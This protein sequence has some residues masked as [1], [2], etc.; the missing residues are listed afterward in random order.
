[1]QHK[2]KVRNSSVAHSKS[3]EPIGRQEKARPHLEQRPIIICVNV[4][5][6]ITCLVSRINLFRSVDQG[7]KI[8][9]TVQ[10]ASSAVRQDK[11]ADGVCV[12]GKGDRSDKTLTYK[13]Q[14]RQRRSA[15]SLTV[16]KR[17][18]LVYK[19]DLL[20]LL[21]QFAIARKT[22]KRLLNRQKQKKAKRF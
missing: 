1:L 14:S 10:S 18:K 11:G 4:V 6:A 2:S 19:I 8:V 21:D 22:Q 3:N 13:G 9:C 5:C 16:E 7:D 20:C 17:S 15:D 12:G